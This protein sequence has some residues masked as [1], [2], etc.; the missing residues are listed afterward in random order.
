VFDITNRKSFDGLLRWLRDARL[1]ADPHYVVLLVGNKIDL[2]SKRS[3]SRKKGEEFARSHELQY[4][5]TSTAQNS[6]IED[7]FVRTAAAILRKGSL[8]A[9]SPPP[10]VVKPGSSCPCEKPR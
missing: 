9:P 7:A 3:V 6:G 4:I 2:E 8:S 10:E 5:E 1:K